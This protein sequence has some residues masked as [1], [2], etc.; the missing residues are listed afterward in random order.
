MDGRRRKGRPK[1]SLDKKPRKRKCSPSSRLHGAEEFF[2]IQTVHIYHFKAQPEFLQSTIPKADVQARDC[3]TTAR[4]SS[5]PFSE[6]WPFV[7]RSTAASSS[8][9]RHA[10]PVTF[11]TI[12]AAI[13][14]L[15]DDVDALCSVE[16]RPGE[17][18]QDA[19]VVDPFHFDWPH[20]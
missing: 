13:K 5:T 12:S 20:W 15:I 4:L 17:Q 10:T 8:S 11:H 14:G 16:T 1:G 18:G 7:Q 3:A 6:R 9:L 19:A 2:D